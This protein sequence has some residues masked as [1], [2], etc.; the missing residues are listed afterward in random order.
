MKNKILIFIASFMLFLGPVFALENQ[1]V[2]DTITDQ[3]IEASE[4][5]KFNKKVSASTILAG[6]NIT[7]NGITDG[8]SF[9]AGNEIANEGISTY[10]VLAGNK[11]SFEGKSTDDAFIAGNE[12]TINGE[13]GR[14]LLVAGYTVKL[15]GSIGRNVTIYAKEVIL[16]NVNVSGNVK[17]DAESV[18]VGANTNIIGELNYKASTKNID[19]SAN[20]GSIRYEELTVAKNTMNVFKTRAISYAS[21]LFLFVIM[22]IFVP[23]CFKRVSEC[24]SN[25]Y[26]IITYIGYALV[27]L[28]LVPVAV[29][30]LIMFTIGVPL[31]IIGIVLYIAI[32]YFAYM[33]TGY[34]IGKNFYKRIG[35]ESNILLEGLIG[36]T[37][38][39]VFSLV[40]VVGGIITLLSY[41]IG[42]GIILFSLKK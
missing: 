22:A 1:P 36:I 30:M 15:S 42:I 12:I 27:F 5:L 39:Y 2:N 31:A 29:L 6:N 4:E 10:G 41:L 33:Y 3:V 26:Q 37:L 13:V 35:R 17:I 21:M 16:E 24:E 34:Y 7:Y 19:S 11:I 28:I 9:I 20:I 40:P 23:S 8:I 14:D 25:F 18:T 32:I 38:L